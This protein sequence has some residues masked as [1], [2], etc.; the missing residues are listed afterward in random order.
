[1]HAVCEQPVALRLVAVGS[2]G[3]DPHSRL[4]WRYEGELSDPAH[5]QVRAPGGY[6]KVAVVAPLVEC[7]EEALARAKSHSPLCNRW[8]VP[9]SGIVY[10][11]LET[12]GFPAP[13]HVP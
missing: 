3:A 4:Y 1:V 10:V 8:K 6:D 9:K 11:Y 2:G 13:P 12:Q 7:P 5:A